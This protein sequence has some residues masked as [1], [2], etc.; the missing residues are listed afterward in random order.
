MFSCLRQKLAQGIPECPLSLLFPFVSVE[1]KAE[2]VGWFTWGEMEG[3]E[4]EVAV[5]LQ[6]KP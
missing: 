4:V 2:P 3:Q 1:E 6:E 5:G